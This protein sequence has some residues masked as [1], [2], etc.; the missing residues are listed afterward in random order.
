MDYDIRDTEA[1]DKVIQQQAHKAALE[2]EEKNSLYALVFN[3]EAGK[4][5]L[6]KWIEEHVHTDIIRPMDNRNQS[7]L[8][9]GQANFV[10]D[11]KN[12]LKQIEK[13]VENGS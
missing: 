8:R 10:M 12:R 7:V 4:R 11:I 1:H 5:L 2:R 3:N 13:G 9:Q 6:D